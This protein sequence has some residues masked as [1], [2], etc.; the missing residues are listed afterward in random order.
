MRLSVEDHKWLD[1][2][3]GS[4]RGMPLRLS[5]GAQEKH[6]RAPADAWQ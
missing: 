6:V 3:Q 5:G 4:D 2:S 1:F